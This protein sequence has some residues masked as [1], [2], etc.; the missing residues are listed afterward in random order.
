MFTYICK[1]AY[2]G[3]KPFEVVRWNKGPTFWAVGKGYKQYITDCWTFKEALEYMKQH[4]LVIDP[5]PNEL[6]SLMK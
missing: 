4:R 5:R 1:K 2:Y 3:F 6:V